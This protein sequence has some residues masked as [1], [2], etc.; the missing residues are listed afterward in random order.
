MPL[1]TIEEKT[2]PTQ[3]DYTVSGH[4]C[5]CH[6]SPMLL[7]VFRI[8]L[9]WWPRKT[10]ASLMFAPPEGFEHPLESPTDQW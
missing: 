1:K 8:C 2:R 10:I 9:P 3:S 5:R 7:L 6:S 4:L